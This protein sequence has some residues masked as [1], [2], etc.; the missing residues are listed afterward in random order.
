MAAV[1]GVYEACLPCFM[2][3]VSLAFAAVGFVVGCVYGLYRYL[4]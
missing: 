4:R 1:P 2:A 3:D